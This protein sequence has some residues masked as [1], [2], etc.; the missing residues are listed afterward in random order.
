[1]VG[2]RRRAVVQAALGL[3]V[4]VP[5]R[6]VRLRPLPGVGAIDVRG[7]QVAGDP[8]EVRIDGAGAAS[9]HGLREGM[10]SNATTTLVRAGR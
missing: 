8:I 4:D 5:R 6:S 3:A 7:L 10:R 1:M 9:I 2:D